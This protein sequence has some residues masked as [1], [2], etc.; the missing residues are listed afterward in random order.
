VERIKRKEEKGRKERES[1]L[2]PNGYETKSTLET[3]VKTRGKAIRNKTI[4]GIWY[5]NKE[6]KKARNEDK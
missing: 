4:V 2:I 6:T 5:N 3:E 1:K